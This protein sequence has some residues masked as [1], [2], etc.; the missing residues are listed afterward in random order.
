MRSTPVMLLRKTIVRAVTFSD[1][2]AHTNTI[3]HNLNIS[4]TAKLK[5]IKNDLFKYTM[6]DIHVCISKTVMYTA[7]IP[8]KT[9]KNTCYYGAGA[10][11]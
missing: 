9:K 2:L 8:A 6:F 10:P 11:K 3:F 5:Q 7:M 1:Y 4:P